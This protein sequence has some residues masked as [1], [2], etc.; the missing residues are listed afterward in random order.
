MS[1]RW[2]FAATMISGFRW[3]VAQEKTALLYHDGR[4]IEPTGT[5][6]TTHIIKPQIGRLPN[7]MDLRDSVENEYLCLKLVE[8][9]GLR[10]AKAQITIF[11]DQKALVIERFDR[12]WARD[13]RLIR[14]PQEDCCQALSVPPT[15][16][17]QNEGGP[18]IVEIMGILRGSD[19]PTQEWLEY[20][21]KSKQ[22]SLF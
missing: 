18:G 20:E 22:L 17:Y 13:G 11:Q 1:R 7:G 12:L 16:K 4:W 8:N 9:F 21:Q 14:L 2:V 19:E 3:Q 5:T 10:V 15:R 6:P